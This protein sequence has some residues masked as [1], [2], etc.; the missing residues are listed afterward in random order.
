MPEARKC[1]VGSV[2]E[3]VNDFGMGRNVIRAR[4]GAKAVVVEVK[5]GNTGRYVRVRWGDGVCV[6]WYNVNRF[7]DVKPEQ[8]PEFRRCVP[9]ALCVA[10][11]LGY[12]VPGEVGK[13]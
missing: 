10:R 11:R 7:K 9:V 5:R 13:C 1:L 4:L 3:F 6:G 2:V 8:M 12:E